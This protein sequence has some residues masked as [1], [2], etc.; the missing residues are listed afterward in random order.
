MSCHI[1]CTPSR[2]TDYSI[3]LVQYLLNSI[4]VLYLL[5]PI[6]ILYLLILIFNDSTYLFKYVFLGL[7]SVVVFSILFI[8]SEIYSSFI[9]SDI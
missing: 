1:C 3:P 8:G 2:S 9:D 7:P 6:F 5:A 4:L